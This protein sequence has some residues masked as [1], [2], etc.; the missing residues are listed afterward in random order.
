MSQAVGYRLFPLIAPAFLRGH[1]PQ[2]LVC[3]LAYTALMQPAL[4]SPQTGAPALPEG[5]PPCFECGGRCCSFH[6]LSIA[7]LSV[8]Q[9]DQPLGR[10]QRVRAT[11]RRGNCETLQRE[12]GEFVDMDWYL[13]ADALYFDCNH[14]TDDGKCGIYDD[15]PEMCQSF[16]CEV[17][18][19]QSSL[20]D[21]LSRL[22]RDEQRDIEGYQDVTAIVTDELEQLA[23]Q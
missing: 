15:R 14:V 5:P 7:W 16:E 2:R 18:R 10:E 17:L 3:R 9:Q 12:S 13:G 11:V 20:D 8:N 1:L 6:T 23:G 19:G 21:F 4:P 22:G